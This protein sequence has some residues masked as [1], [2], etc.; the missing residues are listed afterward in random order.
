MLAI[1]SLVLS[2]VLAYVG[3]I[4]PQ[5]CNKLKISAN[6]QLCAWA[7]VVL[8]IAFIYDGSYLRNYSWE[9]V[10]FQQP[11]WFCLL[12]AAGLVIGSRSSLKSGGALNNFKYIVAYPVLEEILFRG[13]ILPLLLQSG[14]LAPWGACLVCGFLFGG[15]VMLSFGWQKMMLGRAVILV[16]TGY[17]LAAIT[18]AAG[19]IFPAV[20]L[21]IWLNGSMLLLPW[22]GQK[23]AKRT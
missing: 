8:F 15:M 23:I 22:L 12:V 6:L 20:I 9:F 2:V 4:G 7:L 21:H 3:Y 14:L 11:G 18:V 5:L 10:Y 1:V 16:L 17:I 19:S 13:T